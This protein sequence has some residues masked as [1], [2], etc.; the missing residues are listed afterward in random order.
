MEIQLQEYEDRII[1][2]IDLQGFEKE[3]EKINCD[4]NKFH[5]VKKLLTT[6]KKLEDKGAKNSFF[7]KV[8]GFSHEEKEDLKNGFECT[9]ISDTIIYSYPATKNAFFVLSI[10]LALIQWELLWKWNFLIRGYIS[11]GQCF[12][13]DGIIF[14]DGYMKAYSGS[15][16]SSSHSMP[17]ILV[18]D[19]LVTNSSSTLDIKSSL[20]IKDHLDRYFINYGSIIDSSPTRENLYAN[21]EQQAMQ[22]MSFL[23][24]NLKD[25]QGFSK[26]WEKYY[27]TYKYCSSVS[28]L[29]ERYENSNL[30]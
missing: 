23:Q 14:G 12:H 19:L 21:A 24:K 17:Y 2:F 22:G 1:A 29:M 15:E 18:Q 3:I 8:P 4:S 27:W 25:H 6:M 10:E 13:K 30:I 9:V 28:S 26:I 16:K 20:Y 5:S 11:R 7:D